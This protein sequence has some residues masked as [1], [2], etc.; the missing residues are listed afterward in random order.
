M[1]LA[2]PPELLSGSNDHPHSQLPGPQLDVGWHGLEHVQQ[3]VEVVQQGAGARAAEPSIPPEPASPAPRR[4]RVDHHQ[5]RG[6]AEPRPRR[7]RPRRCM[8]RRVERLRE[9]VLARRGARGR[10]P[11][12][13]T[14]CREG[15]QGRRGARRGAG[16]ARDHLAIL[17]RARRK[18]TLAK[19][20]A[21]R[22]LAPGWDGP[23]VGICCRALRTR[24]SR[25]ALAR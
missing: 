18:T 24:I 22:E 1:P 23:R 14:T 17:W 20:C 10:R 19:S 9:H 25:L 5:P 8:C 15:R 16:V 13:A 4:Q 2:S 12:R 11:S 7:S 3:H 21:M 6:H